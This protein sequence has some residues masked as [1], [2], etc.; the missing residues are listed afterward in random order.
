MVRSEAEVERL[1]GENQ[2]LVHLL[3]NRY[4]KSP[5]PLVQA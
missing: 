1:V 5:G 3:V 2:R 4:L